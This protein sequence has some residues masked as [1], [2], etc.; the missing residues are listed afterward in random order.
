MSNGAQGG[1]SSAGAGSR[2]DQNA[3]VSAKGSFANGADGGTICVSGSGGSGCGSAVR[4][5]DDERQAEVLERIRNNPFTREMKLTQESE[6]SAVDI[7]TAM[8]KGT[9]EGDSSFYLGADGKVV[10]AVAIASENGC[11]ALRLPSSPA[12]AVDHPHLAD[13][14]NPQN[15]LARELPGPED[16]SALIDHG[17]VQVIV[18]PSRAVRAVE[19]IQQKNGSFE[20]RLRTLAP[21]DTFSRSRDLQAIGRWRQNWTS[22]KNYDVMKDL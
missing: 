1:Q 9:R 13:S 3:A 22:T 19:V 5:T 8:A 18:T 21:G 17:L 2:Q 14:I 16:L 6:K 20:P 12:I 10:P 7:A 4:K 11:A 15:T